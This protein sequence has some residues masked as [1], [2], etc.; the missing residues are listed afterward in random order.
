M[1]TSTTPVA[2]AQP[3]LGVFIGQQITYH[4]DMTADARGRFPEY[5]EQLDVSATVLHT[6]QSVTAEY[7]NTSVGVEGTI[8]WPAS[9][10]D[11]HV[12]RRITDHSESGSNYQWEDLG[13][14]DVFELQYVATILHSGTVRG[15]NGSN[16]VR[17]ICR[18]P[19]ESSNFSTHYNFDFPAVRSL[20][21]IDDV[22]AESGSSVLLWSNI[23]GQAL[24]TV[25]GFETITTPTMSRQ[26]IRIEAGGN[27]Y[28]PFLYNYSIYMVYYYDCQTG[29]LLEQS[30]VLNLFDLYYPE[31]ADLFFNHTS[32]IELVSTNM[33][34]TRLEQ[35][36]PWLLV[37][38]V[39]C[40]V[41]V[42][43]IL[44]YRRYLRTE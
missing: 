12:Y 7:Y 15:L 41:L 28:D 6:V 19:G 17:T 2:M 39:P 20:F 11:R 25:Q 13:A 33:F 36:L 23:A 10:I 5:D 21:F 32:S 22:D 1:G 34:A 35:I 38:I 31:L 24:Y 9:S 4:C 40:C 30:N 44:I 3:P 18:Y 42:V 8:Q 26:A 29:F 16:A 37:I 14:V 27:F 43:G